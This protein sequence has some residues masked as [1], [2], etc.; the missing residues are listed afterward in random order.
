M[1]HWAQ[2]LLY[3][4]AILY[5][6]SKNS[7]NFIKR[8]EEEKR[9]FPYIWM[10]LPRASRVSTA[11]LSLPTCL[12]LYPLSSSFSSEV[13]GRVEMRGREGL[14]TVLELVAPSLQ[15]PQMIKADES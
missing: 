5:F 7:L 6:L 12:H 10:K 9:I 1:P 8:L 15:A 13:G 2:R 11:S 3:K 14:V 4:R